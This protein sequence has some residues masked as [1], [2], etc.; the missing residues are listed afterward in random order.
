MPCSNP[1]PRLQLAY[2]VVEAREPARWARFCDQFLG[3]PPPLHN[4]DQSLGWRI[5][6]RAQRL[7]V[8]PG[9]SDD[10][11]ALGFDCANDAVLEAQAH[12][13]QRLGHRLSEGDAAACAARRVQRLYA[14]HD[15]EGNRIELASR[16]TRTNEP[17]TAAGFPGGFETG[18]LGLGHAVLVVQDLE[19]MAAFYVEA[20][21][22]GV[23]ERLAT[24]VG[25]LDVRGVFLH[26]SRR[27][28]SLAL[29]QL[30][31]RQRLH[32][33]MLQARDWRDIGPA[34]ERARRLKVPPSLA[35][36]Q[37]PDPD[38]TFSFYAATPSGFDIEIGAGSRTIDPAAW[39]AVETSTTSAWGHE[40]SLRLQW[41][42]AKGLLASKFARRRTAQP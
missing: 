35:L 24:R 6:E 22:F 15:P 27:H 32:H 31:L 38:G 25:P 7:I 41:K 23:T 36:G 17:F 12:Q 9:E 10:L 28:H 20:L 18:E 34:H 2:L 1:P 8:T 16:A 19:A 42:M 4:A 30:P 37:H 26:C 29:F 5:D 40:P 39:Q 13:L 3:L 33:F 21:G 14:L 11:A